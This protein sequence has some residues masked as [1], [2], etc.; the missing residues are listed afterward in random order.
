MLIA[1]CPIHL[2][3]PNKVPLIAVVEVV[4]WALL[5]LAGGSEDIAM[6]DSLYKRWRRE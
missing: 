4:S 1:L 2:V 6:D 5:E 3:C